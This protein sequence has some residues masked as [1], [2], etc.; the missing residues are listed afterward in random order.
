MTPYSGDT[1]LPLKICDLF[2]VFM[3]YVDNH[4]F[5]QIRIHKSKKKNVFCLIGVV[6]TVT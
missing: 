4:S 6:K 1:V 5:T 2:G 3:L